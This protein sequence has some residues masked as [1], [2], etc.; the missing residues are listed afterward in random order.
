MCHLVVPEQPFI[1][2]YILFMHII[3]YTCIFIYIYIYAAFCSIRM[4]VG[5]DSF[6]NHDVYVSLC[7]LG[8]SWERHQ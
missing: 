1:Y 8:W 4:F 7:F 5:I 3:L 2:I 6:E